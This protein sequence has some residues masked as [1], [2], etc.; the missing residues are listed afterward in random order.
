VPRR[1]NAARP[2]MAAA[3][4]G[5]RL[6]PLNA[7]VPAPARRRLNR[8]LAGIAL[9]SDGF[10]PLDDWSHPLLPG[11][12][13][14]EPSGA[15]AVATTDAGDSG[16]SQS[17][18]VASAAAGPS[19]PGRVPERCVLATGALD[20]GG[21]DEMVAFL[22][23]RLSAHG[24]QI[25]V[26]HSCPSEADEGVLGRLGQMLSDAG[27]E[28]AVLSERAGR[29]WIKAWSPDVISAHGAAN[30]VLQEANSLS[31]PYV[32][33]LHGMHSL[34]DIDWEAETRRGQHLAGIVAVSE[35]VRQQ[36]LTGAPEFPAERIVTIPN[37]VDADR[38]L[39]VDRAAARAA[40]G[41][42]DE[43]LF[44]SLAR[45]CLQKNTFGLVA[46]FDDVA[47]RHPEAHLLI[48]GR[49]EDPL[50]CSQVRKLRDGLASRERIHL[51][52]HASDPGLVLSAAD[53]FVLDSF[54]EGWAL[55]S[56][57]ALHAGLPAV[58][59]DVGGAREQIGEHG[60][61]GYVVDNPAGSPL[62]MTWK[63]MR[64]VCYERQANRDQFVDAMS[65]LVV[66][67]ADWTA[68]RE[69]IAA[70][71]AIRF[72]P[73]GCVAQHAALLRSLAE[74]A[75]TVRGVSRAAA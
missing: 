24:L 44:V 54:F 20:V 67:R 10:E 65:A 72:H 15:A 29:E 4:A 37:G 53:G 55:A 34:F 22:A 40:L 74:D 69:Q 52:D 25:A 32:D 56:M 27:I 30:W 42:R 51:R 7:M 28:V 61:L 14:L 58:S 31:V 43:Y 1:L 26:L 70:E 39:R 75:A 68:R 47:A 62:D 38:R 23:R 41:L 36:Y 12:T 11:G 19:A 13:G 59:S 45:H 49:A 8:M 35:L 6:R 48:A 21:M 50:Y 63:S 57:E 5:Q 71:S 3:L 64:S 66:D 18:G 9:R 17:G 16:G 33:V 2:L 46:A 73:D 60:E